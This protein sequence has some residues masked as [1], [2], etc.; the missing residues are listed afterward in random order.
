MGLQKKLNLMCKYIPMICFQPL[1]LFLML[2]FYSVAAGVP[3]D[4][5]ES[6][7]RV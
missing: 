4:S 3:D 1:S 2:T 7:L 5:P 6:A